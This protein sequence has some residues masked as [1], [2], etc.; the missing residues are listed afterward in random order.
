MKLR[1]FD[2]QTDF[3]EIKNWITDERTHAM[4]CANLIKYPLEKDDLERSLRELSDRCGDTPYA[5]TTDDG[6]AVGFFCYSV[7]SVTN[8]GMLKF[9]MV[10]PELRGQGLGKEMVRLACKFAFEKTTANLIQLN[11]F[12][13]NI[14]AQK[15]YESVGFTVRN[16]DADAFC[17]KDESWARIN[18]TISPEKI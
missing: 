4:W 1:P 15:C 14:R 16:T 10:T 3:D 17:F 7:N 13:E 5:A 12:S 18:M 6:K 11:V 8:E 9:V 2:L